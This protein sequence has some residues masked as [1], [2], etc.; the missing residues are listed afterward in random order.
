MYIRPLFS[1][2]LVLILA[3]DAQA[4]ESCGLQAARL[5]A[6][7]KTT[8]LAA[9]FAQPSE[10][11]LPL[12]GQ[13]EN[14]GQLSE[15]QEV[16]SARFA[17]HQRVSIGATDL[18]AS[19]HYQGYWINAVSSTAGPLQ[20]HIASVGQASCKLLALHIDTEK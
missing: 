9:W 14:L 7:G 6:A 15:L 18:P 4:N 19:Y 16:A 20:F 2:I 13:L 3:F 17:Q 10:L 12:Q 8:E 11:A 5:L 1:S